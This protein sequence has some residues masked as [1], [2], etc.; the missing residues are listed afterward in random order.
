[1]TVQNADVANIFEHIADILAIENANPFRIRA[2][3]NAARTVSSLP[4]PV[5]EMVSQ[6]LDLTE[7]PGIGKDLAGKIEEI[8]KTGELQ[9][10]SKLEKEIPQGLARLVEI[11]GIGPKKA[12]Y[13]YKKLNIQSLD[14][15]ER[16]ARQGKIST[17]KGFTEKGESKILKEID[18]FKQ[19]DQSKRTKWVDAH[20]IALS[21][22]KY[23]R[24]LPDIDQIEVA[25]SYRR[26]KVTVGDL[27]LLVTC[28][29][30][31]KVMDHFKA[32][33]EIREVRAMGPT[34]ATVVLKSNLQ[35]DIRVVKKESFGAALLY[36]TGSKAH[37]IHLRKLAMERGYKINEYGMFKNQS[38]LASALE[39]D[40]YKKLGLSYI[41]PELREDMGEIEAAQKKQ[42]PKLI[43]TK[44]LRGD[45]H[46]HTDL[47][48]GQN[49]LEEMA[50]E[51]KRL[52]LEYLAITEHSKRVAVARGLDAKL[53]ERLI[54]KIDKFN[55]T[56]NGFLL[57]KGIEVDILSDGKLDLPDSIL[58]MLDVRV[59]SVH[60]NLNLSMEKM[61]ERI[62]RAMDNPYFNI[63]AHPTGRLINKRP[64]YAVDLEKVMLAAKARGCFLEIN[65]QPHR[66]DLEGEHCKMAKEIG[67]KLAISTDSHS[68]NQLH[69]LEL[70]VAQARRGWLENSDIINTMDWKTL[71]GY[72]KRN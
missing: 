32:F 61:T 43:E 41:G 48:D 5:S 70:G 69:S 2:Y 49:S 31:Q 63:L 7:Y 67:V 47:T 57:L 28:S 55:E 59:C 15:L 27:D 33:D 17:L 16:A 4:K 9:L 3:R 52:G 62:I 29:S 30:P 23:M 39:E 20:E 8:V 46:A 54:K 66:M 72:F 51:A 34:K 19:T 26:K 12:K 45:L 68:I 37:N 64:A 60:Y 42:L 24:E 71:Q 18:S 35:V 10:L 65:C 53:L 58:Q 1:M 11:P 25:G 56:Q 40:I 21:L 38:M 6:H 13:L 44:F 14:D 36:F 22:V 50:M